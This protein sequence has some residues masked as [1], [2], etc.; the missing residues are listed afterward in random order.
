MNV[1]NLEWLRIVYGYMVVGRKGEL[2]RRC[3]F[4]LSN[5]GGVKCQCSRSRNSV[6]DHK[7][8]LSLHLCKVGF[9]PTYEV[10]VH[11]SEPFRQTTSVSEED[12][13]S[14]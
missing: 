6:C 11:H 9:M 4:S 1:L 8:M 2:T 3:G 14:C 7:R 5:N 13:V 12:E 10:W